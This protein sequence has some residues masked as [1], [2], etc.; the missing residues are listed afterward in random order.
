[1][2]ISDGQQRDSAIHI[3]VSIL[4]QTP[5]PSGLP[6]NIEQSS[7]CCTAG[8]WLSLFNHHVMFDSSRPH[9]LQHARL[10][11]PSPPPGVC[12]NWRPLNR[13]CHPTISSSIILFSFCLQSF[14]HFCRLSI[15]NIAVYVSLSL[16]C[17]LHGKKVCS[18]MFSA[19][20]SFPLWSLC[21]LLYLPDVMPGTY[22][23]LEQSL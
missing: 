23:L 17:Y 1:M 16:L 15:F 18:Y 3:H 19:P 6:H 12:L 5:L 9:G 4:P 20:C 11:C 10:P 13:W 2:T 21:D 7:L 8:P 14:D 22:C